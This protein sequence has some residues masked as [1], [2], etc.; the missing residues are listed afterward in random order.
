MLHLLLEQELISAPSLHS[1][2]QCI[3]SNQWVGCTR[4]CAMV[5]RCQTGQTLPLIWVPTN[6]LSVACLERQPITSSN[7][8]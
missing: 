6:L 3:M 1:A 7:T 4:A 2:E 8:P 5:Q